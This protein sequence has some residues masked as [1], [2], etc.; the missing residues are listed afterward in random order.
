[1]AM[2]GG[3]IIWKTSGDDS[4]LDPSIALNGRYVH[5]DVT[6]ICC[7]IC[8]VLRVFDHRF[9]KWNTLYAQN[10]VLQLLWVICGLC[11]CLTKRPLPRYLGRLLLYFAIGVIVNWATWV[12][13]GW[14]W[15][16][17]IWFMVN[18]MNFVLILA[19]ICVLLAPLKNYLSRL[20]EEDI[21]PLESSLPEREPEKNH[22]LG[23]SKTCSGHSLAGIIMVIG[24]GVAVISV[25]FTLAIYEGLQTVC[26]LVSRRGVHMGIGD[27]ET[28]AHAESLGKVVSNSLQACASGLW[29]VLVFARLSS[30]RGAAVWLLLVNFYG[31]RLARGYGSADLPFHGFYLMMVALTAQYLGLSYRQ[32]I[33]KLVHR[34][35]MVVC[36]A[37]A[38]LWTP[39]MR[40]PLMTQPP[41]DLYTR[42][43]HILIEAVCIISWLTAG[44]HMVDPKIFAEDKLSW[45]NEWA[46]V[47]FLVHRGMDWLFPW[48]LPWI[49]LI[50]LG[51]ACWLC[52]SKT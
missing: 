10:W 2:H 5:L 38:F 4:L 43:R 50:A 8:V 3:Q 11:Y 35:W 40:G 47:A 49:I 13:N 45:V 6:R 30:N 20:A 14:S 52:R 48:P 19:V 24:G 25:I 26:K 16:V 46:L 7:I 31:F 22:H 1:M 51:P 23:C 33:G 28:E 42:E 21:R 29:I 18:Q 36:F 27:L 39:G 17:D 32:Q 12:I 41:E 37:L 15:G 34:Y 9:A 44:Q